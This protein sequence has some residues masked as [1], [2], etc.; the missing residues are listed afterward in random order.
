M[1]DEDVYYVG[2]LILNGTGDGQSP[3]I[4]TL[5]PMPRRVM[6]P[7]YARMQ[8]RRVEIVR[9]FV[10]QQIEAIPENTITRRLIQLERNENDHSQHG[11]EQQRRSR[12]EQRLHG[13]EEGLRR[14]INGA[15]RRSSI[16]ASR[17]GFRRRSML[18]VRVRS[19]SPSSSILQTAAA[20]Q[21]HIMNEDDD[22]DLSC[23]LLGAVRCSGNCDSMAKEISVA[24][25]MEEGDPLGAVPNDKLIIV[26]VQPGTLAEGNLKIGDQVLKLNNTVVRDCDHFFQL[27]RFAPPCATITLVRDEKKAAEL[28]AKVHIPPDRAKLITRRDGYMYFVARIEWKPGGPRLGL[29]IKHYQNRVLVSRCDPGSLSSQQLQVGDHLIDIDGHPVTDKDVCR[30]LLLKCLQANR[31]VTT[32]VERP[33]T[34][35]ARYWVQ[36]ALAASTAQAPS[37]AMNSDVRAIAARERQKLQKA[38][39]PKKSCLRKSS[40]TGKR[41]IIV[42]GKATEFIIASDNE[43]KSLR[44]VRK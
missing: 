36:N 20:S 19:L 24:I 2:N 35:E 10:A 33:E 38:I 26:K 5:V 28:E 40:S 21:H 13:S 34:L 23:N 12:S 15:I 7:N 44:H 9:N 27:L 37:V 14:R 8:I 42:E 39:A 29:G 3:Q 4:L 11:S 31:S 32:I 6:A 43:G 22:E 25:P 17:M 16:A 1:T 41:V 18:R 30:E